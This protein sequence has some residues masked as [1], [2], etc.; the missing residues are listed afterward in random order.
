MDLKNFDS[1]P[2]S[3]LLPVTAF[4]T[5]AGIA[6]STVWRRT[7]LEPDFP[8]PVRLGAKCTRFKVGDIRRL[9][10]GQGSA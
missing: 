2:D 5:L 7:S 4:R 9:L 1:L 6:P 10:A 8:K 3:A